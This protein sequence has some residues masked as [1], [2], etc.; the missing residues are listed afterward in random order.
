MRAA[1]VPG[2]FRAV[3]AREGAKLLVAFVVYLAVY[4]AWVWSGARDAYLDM[5]LRAGIALVRAT[6]HFPLDLDRQ[7]F[8]IQ[9]IDCL[10]VLAGCCLVV[11]WRVAFR[12]RLRRFGGL[13]GAILVTHVMAAMFGIRSDVTR[14]LVRDGGP[15]LL[16]PW[17]LQIIVMVK[18]LLY[19][20]GIMLGP[21]ILLALTV[22]WNAG[23][24]LLPPA[25]PP[26]GTARSAGRRKAA[27]AA[28]GV[29]LAAAA[30]LAAWSSARESD[31]RHVR[32][33]VLLGHRFAREGQRD[34]AREQYTAAIVG[35]SVDGKVWFGLARI[36]RERGHLAESLR[37]LE[38]GLEVVKD[39]VWRDRMRQALERGGA[40]L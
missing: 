24:G 8:K 19:N 29:A 5:V 18:Y 3:L 20:V 12:A 10:V 26:G 6:Q 35:G 23:I 16:L 38:S 27:L 25:A 9:Y 39:P 40:S 21:F 14:A 4:P 30:G 17:E 33:H 22:A 34:R 31:P 1:P 11:S 15:A 2:A 36:E 37:L 13:L 32:T 7:D 28:A